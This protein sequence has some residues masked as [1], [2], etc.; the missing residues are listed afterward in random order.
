MTTKFFLPGAAL[1]G[2]LT[3]GAA[4]G[5]ATVFSGTATFTDN[6]G[7]NSVNFTET[8]ID[9]SFS[10]T[11]TA[12]GSSN[13]YVNTDFVTIL[14]TDTGSGTFADNI[15]LALSFTEPGVGSDD[16]TGSAQEKTQGNTSSGTVTWSGAVGGV[17]TDLVSFADG[18][19]IEVEIFNA[20]LSSDGRD[21][22][23]GQVEVKIV[24]LK[25]PTPTPVPEPSS[26]VLLASALFGIGFVGRRHIRKG[27][28]LA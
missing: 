18:A 9:S 25:D 8:N 7:S 16:Q 3:L 24:D 26:L 12:G 17:A 23:N 6:G 11:L 19:L 5:H 15:T 1:L 10:A 13:T 27:V 20:T 28:S 21:K 4:T 14:G 2:A 22:V